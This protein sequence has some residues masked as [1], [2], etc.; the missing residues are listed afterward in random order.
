MYYLCRKSF[1]TSIIIKNSKH[2]LFKKISTI[3]ADESIQQF[4]KS[5]RSHLKIILFSNFLPLPK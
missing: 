4:T 2:L 5:L 3:F 1:S